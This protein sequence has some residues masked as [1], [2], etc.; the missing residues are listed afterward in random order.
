MSVNMNV[1][2]TCA[3]PDRRSSAA[4]RPAFRRRRV[5]RR[6]Q[7]AELVEGGPQLEVGV[8]LVVEQP[9]RR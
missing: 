6:A 9:Q 7:P 4:R 1:I 8:V 3:A 2:R 5:D